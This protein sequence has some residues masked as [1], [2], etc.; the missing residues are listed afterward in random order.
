LCWRRIFA[1]RKLVGL[2]EL[3]QVVI[4]YGPVAAVRD[5]SISVDAGEVVALVG[6]NGA[7]KSTTLSTIAGLLRPSAGNMTFDSRSIVGRRPEELV[8]SGISLVPEGRRIFGSLTVAENLWLG[9]T[10]RRDRTEA[11]KDVTWVLE[12]FPV[13]ATAYHMPAGQLS[14]GEQQQLAIARA[15]LTRPKLLMLD[16]PSLGLAPRVVDLVFE[17]LE[18]LRQAG[19]TML[20]VEQSALRAVEFADRSYVMSTGTVVI[21][22]TRED[23]ANEESVI[24]AYLGAGVEAE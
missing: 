12:L 13:L 14:G 16:E 3:E 10:V 18:R 20:L 7:G 24:R 8:R 22:G 4:R 15:L 1:E 6:P 9:T 11:R 19:T 5:V 21:S 23:L 17:V 2:L